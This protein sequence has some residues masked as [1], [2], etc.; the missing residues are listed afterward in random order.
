MCWAPRSSSAAWSAICWHAGVLSR[1]QTWAT[2]VSRIKASTL[3]VRLDLSDMPSELTTL[4]L[5]FNDML[6]RLEDAFSRISRYPPTSPTS[7]APPS[8]P[9]Q[10]HRGRAHRGR[11]PMNIATF[12]PPASK[13]AFVFRA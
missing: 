13:N 4:A 11:T 1:W 12:S 9:A 5:S 2:T 3:D 7:C 8:Q 10:R 6:S